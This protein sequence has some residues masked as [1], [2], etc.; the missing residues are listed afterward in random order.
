MARDTPTTAL[1]AA[2]LA[3]LAVSLVR[4]SAPVAVGEYDFTD[5]CG[6]VVSPYVPIALNSDDDADD[7]ID[8]RSF[9]NDIIMTCT[10]A[11]AARAREAQVEGVAG[12]LLLGAA[13]ARGARSRRAA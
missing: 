7:V 2:G 5:N 1:A 12:G 6:S 11:Y 3:L 9:L 4:I 8:G 13:V 10:D